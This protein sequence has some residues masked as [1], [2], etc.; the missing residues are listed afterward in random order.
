MTTV[1]G[2][3][4]CDSVKKA[5]TWLKKKNIPFTFHDYRKNGVDSNK[6]NKWCEAKGWE[7]ILNKKSSSWRAL[8]P[9]KQAEIADQASAIQLMEEIP[10]LIKRP[11]IEHK[12]KILVGYDEAVY[13]EHIK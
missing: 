3:P 4:S 12:R 6:L 2:I 1:Y 7:I 13:A 9:E 11:V 8:T 5:Q 10:T